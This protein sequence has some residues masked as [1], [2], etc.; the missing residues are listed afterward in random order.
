MK[1]KTLKIT[2]AV[3]AVLLIAGVTAYAA[4]NYGTKDDPLITKSYLDEVV[5]PQFTE[6]FRSK[7]DAAAAEIM[8]SAPGEFAK[9]ELKSGQTLYCS[10][11]AQM[12]PVEGSLSAGG[13]LADTTAGETVSAG[14]AMLVNHLY[15]AGDACSAA[16][17]TAAT[18]LVGG[19]YRVD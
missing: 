12:L 1:E 2:V 3:L 15:L 10:A 9:V 19:A 11:G 5:M 7:L 13:A 18:V 8:H 4:T 16:A 14:A 6:E 17:S